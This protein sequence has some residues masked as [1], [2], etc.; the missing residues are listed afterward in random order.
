MICKECYYSGNCTVKPTS[1]DRCNVFLKKKKIKMG[2]EA[3]VN[4]MD[5][6]QIDYN[7]LK[8]LLKDTDIDLE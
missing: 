7:D 6:T 3:S 5:T 4:P 2:D 8:E 1:E